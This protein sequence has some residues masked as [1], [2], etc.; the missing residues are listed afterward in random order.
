[1]IGADLRY[2]NRAA[3][4]RPTIPASLGFRTKPSLKGSLAAN[5]PAALISR[6]F[7]V[8]AVYPGLFSI[9]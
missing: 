6:L 1:M 9:R 5:L 2:F 3:A 8:Y 4:L 7:G